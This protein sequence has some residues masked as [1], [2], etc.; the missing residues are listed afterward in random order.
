MD[1]YSAY[2]SNFVLALLHSSTNAHLMHWT[3]NSFSKHMALG[4]YYDLVIEQS[5]AYAEAYMGKY[6][7]LKKFPNEYHPPNND[8]IKYFE[9]L[10]KFVMDIRKELPQDSELNQLVDN[11]QENIDST[12]YKLKYLD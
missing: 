7:Q 12:L 11:I 5:D 3:T 1:K 4:T 10:S 6:G 8:T 9:T 2:V